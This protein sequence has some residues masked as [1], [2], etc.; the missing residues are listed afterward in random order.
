MISRNPWVKIS[1]ISGRTMNDINGYTL[2][3]ASVFFGQVLV[4]V[5]LRQTHSLVMQSCSKVSQCP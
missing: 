4:G 1:E 2:W 5:R 3:L